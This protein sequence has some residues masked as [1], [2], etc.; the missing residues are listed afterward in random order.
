MAQN[1]FQVVNETHLDHIMKDNMQK[2]ILIMFSSEMCKPCK[3]F[4]PKFV[5]MAKTN[6]NV[7]FIYI[8]NM[9]YTGTENKYFKECTVT[10]TFL[11]YF[12]N[13]VVAY[14]RGIDENALIENLLNIEKK[15]EARKKQLSLSS[16]SSVPLSSP[17]PVEKQ[18]EVE[19]P[20]FTNP[21]T[22]LMQKKIFLFNKLT[23]L[24]NSGVKLTGAY[25][26]DSDYDDL[27]FEYRYQVDPAF[28][29]YILELQQKQQLQKQQQLPQQIPQQLPQQLPLEQNNQPQLTI[30]QLQ[31]QQLQAQQLQAQQLQAQQLQ[32]QQ[33]QAQQLQAQQLQAQQLQAQQLQTPQNPVL[34]PEE[35]ELLKKQQKIEQIKG[36]ANLEQKMQMASYQKLIQLKK[37]QQQK[38]QMEKNQNNL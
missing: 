8:D 5:N 2:L 6:K 22:E 29:Q 19:K 16:L 11:Y 18:I 28:K 35:Q 32:A 25:T 9:N 33:L 24:Y 26:I 27:L 34:T 15:I 36:L 17:L 4:K 30:Q 21:D 10:P 14:I 31:A 13:T 7:L 37:L 3:V 1:I 20:K 38:E 12:S 23:E